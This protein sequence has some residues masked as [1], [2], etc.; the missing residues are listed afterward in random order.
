MA[1]E[2]AS[3]PPLSIPSA[4]SEVSQGRLAEQLQPRDDTTRY[5]ALGG[6]IFFGLSALA[7]STMFYFLFVHRID[8][9]LLPGTAPHEIFVVFLSASLPQMLSLLS[10]LITA[11]IGYALLRSAGTARREVIPRQDARLLYQLLLEKNDV[12]LTNYIRLA[13]LS[14]FVDFCTKLGIGGL[15]LATIGLT[16]F[17]A[18]L[19]LASSTSTG[20]FDLAKLTLGA[21]I[22]SYVQRQRTEFAAQEGTPG[23]SSQAG[24]QHTP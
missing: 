10:G 8:I 7:F 19:G 13:S 18:V 11:L 12:A 24:T 9:N 17:F 20:F 16:I 4:Q 22:G 3:T 6:Y 14:G 23:T 21:F 5:L 15:P 1:E 2:T